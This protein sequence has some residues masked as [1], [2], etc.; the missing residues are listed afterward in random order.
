MTKL[1]AFVLHQQLTLRRHT[2]CFAAA[3]AWCHATS[4]SMS[5]PNAPFDD[6]SDRKKTTSD[7]EDDEVEVVGFLPG[8]RQEKLGKQPA[9]RPSQTTAL[10][11][12][13]V[14]EHEE[15]AAKWK[16][17]QLKDDDCET[18]RQLVART[19]QELDGMAVER[20]SQEYLLD[21]LDKQ[22]SAKARERFALEQQLMA[23]KSEVE[24]LEQQQKTRRHRDDLVSMTQ[25]AAAKKKVF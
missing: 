15:G 23:I 19:R 6:L 3:R 20:A 8:T 17:L 4:S 21:N 2:S 22:L 25:A 9:S 16:L 7:D 5:T 1:Q 10:V 24:A 13:K 12:R 14:K 11:A 18:K